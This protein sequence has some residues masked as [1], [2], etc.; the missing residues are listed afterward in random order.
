[1]LDSNNDLVRLSD[2]WPELPGAFS[3]E[4][5][6]KAARFFARTEVV[7]W[8]PGC[9]GGNPLALAPLPD[10]AA[11]RD[12]AEE[13]EMA[14]GMAAATLE[15]L[16]PS[17]G[18]RGQLR[19]GVLV[20]ALRH[21]ARAGGGPLQDLVTL[22]RELP[23]DVCDIGGAAQLAGEVADAL[24]AARSRNPL[25]DGDGTAL[26][27]AVLLGGASGRTRVSV[28][29]LAGLP[30]EE[31]R[32]DFVGR[33][34]MA[35]FG[36]IRSHPAGG[37]LP[38]S[39]LLVMDEAQ[40]FVPS[41]RA[42]P[43]RSATVALV[44]QARKYGLGMVFAT[45]APKAIDHNII[46]NCTTQLF[47]LTNSPAAL[48]AVR[49]MLRSRGGGGEDLGRLPRGQFYLTT[50]G[51]DRPMKLQT[52]LCLTHHPASPPTEEEIIACAARCRDRSG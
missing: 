43:S 31:A 38:A 34:L 35:L 36:Y 23:P 15:K 52:P 4:D 12:D 44:R 3:D 39:G 14:V 8:T 19:M 11:L 45:Q 46:A 13:R 16:V 18:A 6:A 26:D 47:G 10:F 28:V 37:E 21:F 2:P 41:D 51:A 1:M 27:P 25:L 33:L 9:A 24:L 22:L 30:G 20:D 7:V 40:N 5:A 42:G 50:E 29:N 32:Q 17:G 49:E 48:D